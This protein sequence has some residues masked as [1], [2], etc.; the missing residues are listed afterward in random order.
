MNK[1]IE[2]FDETLIAKFAIQIG[3]DLLPK[4]VIK[5]VKDIFRD[6]IGIMVRS[7]SA[8]ILSNLRK[9]LVERDSGVCTVFGSNFKANPY[10]ASFL[11]ASLPTVIQ[12]DEGHRFTGAHPGI[13]IIPAAFAM[14]EY[15][16]VSGKDLIVAILLGYEVSVRIGFSVLPMNPNIHPHGNWSIIGAAVSAGKILSFSE[17]QY[18]DLINSI[19][20][21]TLSTWRKA[22]SSGATIHH[23]APGLGTSQAIAA[24]LAI[25]AGMTGAP[26]S[27][28]NFFLPLHATHPEPEIQTDSLGTTYEIM[29]NYFKAYPCC[30]HIHSSIDALKNILATRPISVNEIDWVEVRIYPAASHLKEQNPP[31]TLAGIFSIRL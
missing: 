20:T 11:N 8:S 26:S 28:K 13:H 29:N 18:V 23:L 24:T 3:F 30:A 6:T 10:I 9:T 31:N 21:L 27:L 12:Y 1:N 14:G 16:R 25:Q 4:E 15:K 2:N 5:R 7:T 19:S 17:K 22:T